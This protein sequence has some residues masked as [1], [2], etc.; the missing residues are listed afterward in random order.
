MSVPFCL[1]ITTAPE[2]CRPRA[3]TGWQGLTD[4]LPVNRLYLASG[5]SDLG[6]RV[7][8]VADCRTDGQSRRLTDGL[9]QRNIPF[10]PGW[11]VARS[12]GRNC[13]EKVTLTS[14]DGTLQRDFEGGFHPIRIR[15]RV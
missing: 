13:V 5:M 7:L 14:I 15:L 12:H 10:M 3:L 1:P 9:D 6:I 11:T 2:S 4:C 8:A